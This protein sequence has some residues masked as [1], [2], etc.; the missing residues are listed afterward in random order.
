PCDC[1]RRRNGFSAVRAAHTYGGPLVQALLRFKHGGRRDLG[2]PLGTLL[3][4]ALDASIR[5]VQMTRGA[6]SVL[7]AP[8]PL[9]RRRLR[10]R[11][12]N[13]AL[14][15]ARV[16]IRELRKSP[17]IA[18]TENVQLVPDL[19]TRQRDTPSLGTLGVTQR[20]AIV[21]GA[22]SVRNRAQVTGRA[23]VLVDD[24]MTTGATMSACALAL[25]DAGADLVGAGVLAGEGE[26]T[27]REAL[28][29]AFLPRSPLDTRRRVIKRV[30]ADL[31]RPGT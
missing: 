24:V 30:Q 12:Y 29:R 21:E 25:K 4:P 31:K 5:F 1:A 19:L 22:F 9:H 23:V 28:L 13:Q 18:L 26:S 17:G 14:D 8:V 15:L 7:V 2:S 10:Q 11:G 20:M 6:A 16:G 3:S 27:G